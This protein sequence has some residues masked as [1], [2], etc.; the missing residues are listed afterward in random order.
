MVNEIRTVMGRG[1]LGIS[2]EIIF[3]LNLTKNGNKVE[4][5]YKV[6]TL[7]CISALLIVQTL[8]PFFVKLWKWFFFLFIPLVILCPSP[9]GIH[10]P[11]NFTKKMDVS[12]YFQQQKKWKTVMKRRVPEKLVTF[13]FFLKIYRNVNFFWIKLIGQWIP[14]GD[15]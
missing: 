14:D 9:F 3:I 1:S 2:K 11:I 12:V 8:W 4:T 6:G 13:P 10:W 15:G 7:L 5:I